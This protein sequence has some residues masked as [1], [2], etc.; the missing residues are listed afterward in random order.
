MERRQFLAAGALL[1][2]TTL[3][4]CTNH[5]RGTLPQT[6]EAPVGVAD[7]QFEFDEPDD[8]GDRTNPPTVEC[9]SDDARVEIRGTSA[10]GNTSDW[11]LPKRMDLTG[12]TFEFVVGVY[13]N[14]E[15]GCGQVLEILDY[16][17][18]FE[19]ESSLPAQVVAVEKSSVG[20]DSP[21]RTEREC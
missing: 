17:A 18:T 21:Q 10:A 20:G 7:W 5:G 16:E 11:L 2:A 15:S 12:D 13:E 4:G 9:V 8:V 19:F 3:A 1:G 14:C 6:P